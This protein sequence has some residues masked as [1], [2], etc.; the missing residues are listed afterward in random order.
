MIFFNQLI[1]KI[2]SL[3]FAIFLLLFIAFSSGLGTFIPQ[4][5]KIQDY[6]DNYDANP[7]FG[8]LSGEKILMLE[9]DHIYTSLWFLTALIFLCISLALSSIRK[10]IPTFRAS[11]EWI[12]YDNKEKFNKLQLAEQ[13]STNEN[14]KL[15]ENAN[16][17]LKK[18]GWNLLIKKNR[19][20]ARK[21]VLGRV[22]PI[23]VHTGLIFLLIGSAYGNFTRKTIEQYL[24]PNEGIDLINDLSNKKLTLKL[25]K[26]LIERESNG[27][28]S[29]YTSN[30]EII[31]Y[32]PLEKVTKEA[33]VN[34]PIRYEGLTI[35]QAEWAISKII[36]EIDQNLFQL[37]LKPVPEIG[38]QIWGIVIE[39]GKGDKKQY[40]L[41]I[42]NENG[43]LKVFNI[44][45]FLA[46]D[47]YLNEDPIEINSSKLI[48]KKI[49][50]STGLIIKSDPSIPVIYSAF[51]L[52]I[53]GASL[54]LIPTKRLWLLKDSD[55]RIFYIG[56]LCNK[57]L[58]G[59]ESEFNEIAEQI[60]NY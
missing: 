39:L 20:L 26:F 41:A 4:G 34:H 6:Y 38:E 49:I 13:W 25:N 59:F 31:S 45:N 42:D 15:I 60:K 44:E 16:T 54:S 27:L 37:S 1:L 8:F 3:K 50:P 30:V 55:S 58:A 40:L 51:I 36:L 47:V 7:I 2:S 56:G 5:Q 28:P 24:V 46:T 22:G 11:L 21:G 23:L 17:I 43:P 52:I 32:N 19:I 29:Q 18:E 48:L 12:D 10:Q 35:Y 33:Q 53:F 14:N 57:N 9:L